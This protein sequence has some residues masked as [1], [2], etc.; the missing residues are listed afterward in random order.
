MIL[1]LKISNGVIVDGSGKPQYRGDVGIKDGRI[2][3][4]GRV[5]EPARQEIDA[6]GKVV[7]PGFVDVHTH[8]DAQVF[9]DPSLSP[10][11]YH[12]VTTIIGGYCGFSIAPLSPESAKYLMPMLARVEG[13]PLESLREGVQVELD[14]IRGI[15]QPIRRYSRDQCRIPRGAFHNP[16]LCNGC[17]CDQT[18]GD[19]GGN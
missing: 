19:T 10:S 4:L 17:G 18:P 7:A 8:Y 13:M 1:D 9:W 16:P 14:N 3:V 5:S 2:A 11:S 6:K 15:P 12:G